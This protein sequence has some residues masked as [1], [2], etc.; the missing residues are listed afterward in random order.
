LLAFLFQTLPVFPFTVD[1]LAMLKQ[2][3]IV[4]DPRK[5]R[6]WR[7]AFD[8]PMKRYEDCVRKAIG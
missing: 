2:E 6:E 1:Q 8:L 7:E 4:K 3:N 5:E